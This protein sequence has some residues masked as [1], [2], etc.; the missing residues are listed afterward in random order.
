[1]QTLLWFNWRDILYPEA[2]GAGIFSHKIMKRLTERGYHIILFTSRFKRYQLNDNID[3]VDII[4]E[5]NK[6]TVYRHAQEIFES[7]QASL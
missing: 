3:G 2:A 6:Y 4:R 7:I 1:M 5:G